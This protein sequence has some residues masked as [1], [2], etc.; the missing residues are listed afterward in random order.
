MYILGMPG[1][2]A[3]FAERSHIAPLVGHRGMEPIA[4]TADFWALFWT[5]LV[6]AVFLLVPGLVY[7]Y[8]VLERWIDDDHSYARVMASV[9]RPDSRTGS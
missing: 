4:L 5:A 6:T 3:G 1:D 7:A 2:P 8:Y 9:D